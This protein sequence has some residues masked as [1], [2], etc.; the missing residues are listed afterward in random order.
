MK[1]IKYILLVV[2]IIV[3]VIVVF[4]LSLRWRSEEVYSKV[5]VSGNHTISEKEIIKY[6]GLEDLKNIKSD[7]IKENE[8]VERLK[9]HPDIKKAFV[10]KNPPSEIKIEIIEKTPIAF[11]N[12]NNELNLIDEEIEIIPFKNTG[13]I[14]D[15]PIINGI[16]VEK[17][18]MLSGY[19]KADLKVAISILMAIYKESK[20]LSDMISEIN[21]SDKN[22]IVIF[23]HDYAIPIFIPKYTEESLKDQNMRLELLKKIKALKY[24]FEEI[25]PEEKKDEIDNINLSYSNQLIISFKE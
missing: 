23:T 15:L 19:S 9:T 14:Y 20:F 24:F 4:V 3:I 11:I 13:K 18:K 17:D 1:K 6:A 16:K 7:E 21:M 22:F 12:V 2:V 25:Y 10:Q 8:I 5:I